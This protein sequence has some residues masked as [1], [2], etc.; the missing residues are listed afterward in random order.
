M[1]RN[2]LLFPPCTVLLATCS[3][4]PS[5]PE[6]PDIRGSWTG[7]PYSWNWTENYS[8]DP[9]SKFAGSCAGTLVVTS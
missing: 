3:G 5:G 2:R 9:G 6:M 1:G 7:V 8:L 4:S